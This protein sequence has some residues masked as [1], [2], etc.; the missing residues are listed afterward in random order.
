MKEIYPYNSKFFLLEAKYLR[1][2]KLNEEAEELLSNLQ[3]RFP[4]YRSVYRERII[5]FLHKKEVDNAKIV[6]SQFRDLFLYDYKE[7]NKI[8]FVAVS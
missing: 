3:K 5:N 2:K 4:Y 8:M 6:F 7:M 1:I